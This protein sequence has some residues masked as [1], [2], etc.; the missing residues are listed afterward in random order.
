MSFT[1]A[2]SLWQGL[3]SNPPKPSLAAHP[4]PYPLQGWMLPPVNISSV[5]EDKARRCRQSWRCRNCLEKKLYGWILLP[6]QNYLGNQIYAGALQGD[7][8]ALGDSDK[9]AGKIPSEMQK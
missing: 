8:V 5:L 6:L 2:T 7:R 9:P 3:S 1:G 4:D